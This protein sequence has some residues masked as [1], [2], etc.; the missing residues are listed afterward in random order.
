MVIFN[1]A[2]KK[3]NF[4]E[5]TATLNWLLIKNNKNAKKMLISFFLLQNF[6]IKSNLF[7]IKKYL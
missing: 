7:V 5:I 2:F 4:P 1:Q 6:T 3:N